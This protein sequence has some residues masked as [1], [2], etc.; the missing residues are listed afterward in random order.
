LPYTPIADALGLAPLPGRYFVFLGA[1]V[2]TYLAIVEVVKQRVMR[3][4]LL[5]MIR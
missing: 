1:V 2:I 3:R 5:G 4:L